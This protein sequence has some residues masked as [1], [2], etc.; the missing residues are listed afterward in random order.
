[1]NPQDI[2][3]LLISKI[4]LQKKRDK[5]IHD[6]MVGFVDTMLDL[7]RKLAESKNPQTKPILKRQI[8]ATD[9]QIDKLVYKLYDL[10][11]EEIEIV[12]AA[13]GSKK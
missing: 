9:R 1:M 2:K 3:E 6:Q 5:T 13:G 10:T 8:E 4:D 7:N 12:E 11:D